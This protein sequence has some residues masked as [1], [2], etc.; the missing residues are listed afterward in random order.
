MQYFLEC[1]QKFSDVFSIEDQSI[2]RKILTVSGNQVCLPKSLNIMSFSIYASFSPQD[3]R[4][5]VRRKVM[6]NPR[7]PKIKDKKKNILPGYA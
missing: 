2:H 4:G 6:V 5:R 3:T 1:S 7:F